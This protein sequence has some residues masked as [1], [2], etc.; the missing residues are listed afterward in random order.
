VSSKLS[1]RY[2]IGY[3]TKGRQDICYGIRARRIHRRSRPRDRGPPRSNRQVTS[4]GELG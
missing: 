2:R 1:I 4:G 3:L